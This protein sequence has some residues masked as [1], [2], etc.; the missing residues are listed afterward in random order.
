[1]DEAEEKITYE[2]LSE[3]ECMFDDVDTEMRTF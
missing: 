1:M 2:R 3:L